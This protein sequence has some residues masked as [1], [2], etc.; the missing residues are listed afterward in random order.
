VEE[1]E[2]GWRNRTEVRDKI[3]VASPHR[4]WKPMMRLQFKFNSTLLR[5]LLRETKLSKIRI[6][7]KMI[8]VE[9]Q[10]S[11]QVFIWS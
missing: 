9:S 6:L 4:C 11:H 1:K 8:K 3:V 7:F 10:T 2:D 5:T